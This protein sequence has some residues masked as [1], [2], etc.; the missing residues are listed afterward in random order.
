MLL[1]VSTGFLSMMAALLG[2]IATALLFPFWLIN[3]DASHRPGLHFAIFTVVGMACGLIVLASLLVSAFSILTKKQYGTAWGAM[4][5][6]I[7]PIVAVTIL[8]HP[9]YLAAARLASD[10]KTVNQTFLP[11][12]VT[13]HLLAFPVFAACIGYWL[14]RYSPHKAEP[15]SSPTSP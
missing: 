15:I 5:L 6:S 4:M 12:Y 2:G 8:S 11:V 13:L 1:V 14:A 10:L 7:P 3:A 9:G